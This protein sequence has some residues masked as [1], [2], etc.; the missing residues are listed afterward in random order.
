MPM[1]PVHT[2]TTTT[3]FSS[4][5]Q[6]PAVF[7]SGSSGTAFNRDVQALVNSTTNLSQNIQQ[8]QW[9]GQPVFSRAAVLHPPVSHLN[10]APQQGYQQNYGGYQHGYQSSYQQSYQPG[11]QINQFNGQGWHVTQH[12]QT[13]PFQAR[14]QAQ[15]FAQQSLQPF[16]PPVQHHAAVAAPKVTVFSSHQGYPAPTVHFVQQTP[17]SPR[18]VPKERLH[19]EFVNKVAG[20]NFKDKRKSISG[21]KKAFKQSTKGL[22]GADKQWAKN[23][24]KLLDQSIH[25]RGIRNRKT[26]IDRNSLNTFFSILEQQDRTPH[27]STSSRFQS[28]YNQERL[29]SGLRGRI[30]P[31]PQPKRQVKPHIRPQVNPEANQPRITIPVVR[32]GATKKPPETLPKP[33]VST[34]RSVS[35]GST[36]TGP[37][38]VTPEVSY[39]DLNR[40]LQL[41]KAGMDLQDAVEESNVES[42]QPSMKERL[43]PVVDQLQQSSLLEPS[44]TTTTE[45]DDDWLKELEKLEEVV[46]QQQLKT[47]DDQSKTTSSTPVS[48]PPTPQTSVPKRPSLVQVGKDAQTLLQHGEKRSYDGGATTLIT[49]LPGPLEAEYGAGAGLS[50]GQDCTADELTSAV[51]SILQQAVEKGDKSLALTPFLTEYSNLDNDEVAATWTNA[52]KTFAESHD[53]DMPK[54]FFVVNQL[55][56]QKAEHTR[57][58]TLSMAGLN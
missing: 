50:C 23:M 45:T 40:E 54:V 10:P 15:Y 55:D 14:P 17:T 19:L 53:G 47:S 51:T 32:S 30:G 16:Q 12:V 27:N 2:T 29:V 48:T 31:A 25:T 8:Q 57:L 11:Y 20:Q 5:G 3:V 37:K 9:T 36:P 39:K 35:S 52:V 49:G 44:S 46:N 56:A 21:L 22:K 43:Q 41:I 4:N 1:G 6:P 42:K 18:A 24:A 13:P 26:T 58:L 34:S 7:H 28:V 38:A 33:P